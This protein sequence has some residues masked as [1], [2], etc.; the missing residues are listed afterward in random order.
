[1]F[2]RPYYET[3]YEGAVSATHRN[4]FNM[5]ILSSNLKK[6]ASLLL[7]PVSHNDLLYSSSL[8]HHPDPVDEGLCPWFGLVDM[9]SAHT[10]LVVRLWI[11]TNPFGDVRRFGLA[12]GWKAHTHSLG[13]HAV[14][15]QPPHWWRPKPPKGPAVKRSPTRPFA[16][17]RRGEAWHYHLLFFIW[18][19]VGSPYIHG[20]GNPYI[21]GSCYCVRRMKCIGLCFIQ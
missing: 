3:T 7:R 21:R 15:L 18:K 1:M 8:V 4:A 19:N 16:P 11:S 6:R 17:P 10:I 2:S 9:G 13:P 12:C 20:L 5:N 14:D